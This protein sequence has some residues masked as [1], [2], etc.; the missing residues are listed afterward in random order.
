M[1]ARILFVRKNVNSKGSRPGVVF[2]AALAD[3]LCVVGFAAAGRSQH[4][5][6]ATLAGLWQTAWPFLA[7]LAIVWLVAV[8][9]RRP[10]AVLRS[11]VPAWLGT[12]SVGMVMRVIFTDGGAPLAFVLVAAGTLGV[13]LVGWRLLAAGIFRLRKPR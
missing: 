1:G 12:L 6:A 7:A 3:A 9:W 10:L 8:V 11:G 4:A 5:E 2:A 13:L